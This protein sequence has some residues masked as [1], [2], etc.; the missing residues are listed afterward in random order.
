M[1]S[2]THISLSARGFAVWYARTLLPWQLLSLLEPEIADFCI[3]Q[4]VTWTS[5]LVETA[6]AHE[7]RPADLPS[8][9][10]LI[11]A[12]TLRVTLKNQK[13]EKE[14]DCKIRAIFES[15]SLP[16]GRG[17]TSLCLSSTKLMPAF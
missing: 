5:M 3:L 9:P 10:A 15:V 8:G 7:G 4:D 13:I 1:P 12:K 6:I 17:M 2:R 16:D 11:V 14:P